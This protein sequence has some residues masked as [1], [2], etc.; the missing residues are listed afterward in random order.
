[1]KIKVF[2]F[3]SILIIFFIAGDHLVILGGKEDRYHIDDYQIINEL[4]DVEVLGIRTQ[5]E[6]NSTDL[7]D[8]RSNHASVYS[9]A[10]QSLITCGGDEDYYTGR[11]CNV[12]SVNGHQNLMPLMNSARH[13][14]AMVSIRNQIF[15]IGGAGGKGWNT[16]ETIRLNEKNYNW[17]E[18][19]MPFGVSHHC[20]VTLDD[21]IIVIGG[22]A[23]D[24]KVSKKLPFM[25]QLNQKSN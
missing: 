6:C 4:S 18:Q 9:F 22:I 5:S 14:F 11:S 17:S 21:N 13:H 12:Q 19:S 1:M 15:A 7:P 20:A 24:W 2:H 3:I 16:M 8:R 23:G 10:H 25:Q